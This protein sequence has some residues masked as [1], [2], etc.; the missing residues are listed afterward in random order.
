[1]LDQSMQGQLFAM[2]GRLGAQ[3]PGMLQNLSMQIAAN[4][5]Q[6]IAQGAAILTALMG[7]ISANA[8]KCCPRRRC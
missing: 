4:L 2:I 5:P 7:T 6:M 8:P 3:L 1:M